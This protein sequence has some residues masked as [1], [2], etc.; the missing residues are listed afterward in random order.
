[1]GNGMGIAISEMS[2][3][4]KLCCWFTSSISFSIEGSFHR[5][6]D[7]IRIMI[8]EMAMMAMFQ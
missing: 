2:L 4:W 7:A 8:E 3:D 1:M 5:R 6:A